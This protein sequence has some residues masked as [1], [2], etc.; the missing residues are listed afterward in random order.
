MGSLK[1]E[2]LEESIL[3]TKVLDIVQ[4]VLYGKVPVAIAVVSIA[5]IIFALSKFLTPELDPLEPPCLKPTIPL[6]GHI[7]GI[8]QHQSNYHKILRLVH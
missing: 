2:L 6:V 7:I 8:I 4:H 1:A 5:L 3:S